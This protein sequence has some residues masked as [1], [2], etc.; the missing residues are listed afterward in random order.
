[1]PRGKAVGEDREEYHEHSPTN[2]GNTVDRVLDNFR[3][4]M[5]HNIK[6]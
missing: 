3:V 6:Q 1:M 4:S 2:K 5:G